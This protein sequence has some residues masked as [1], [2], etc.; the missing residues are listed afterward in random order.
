MWVV[1][2]LHEHVWSFCVQV[3]SNFFSPPSV[4]PFYL[5]K[6]LVIGSCLPWT[7]QVT[8]SNVANPTKEML[9]QLPKNWLETCFLF[10]IWTQLLILFSVECNEVSFRYDKITFRFQQALSFYFEDKSSLLQGTRKQ[11]YTWNWIIR[12]HIM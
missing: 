4:K 10:C 1:V 9:L 2:F 7:L 6:I 12:Y 5:S 8:T 3:S 11:L